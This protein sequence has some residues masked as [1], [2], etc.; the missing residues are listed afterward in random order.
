MKFRHIVAIALGL[1]AVLSLIFYLI[2]EPIQGTSSPLFLWGVVISAAVAFLAGL[3]QIIN[4]VERFGNPRDFDASLKAYLGWV[5][6]EYSRLDLRGVEERQSKAHSLTL[7]DVYV[8]LT[9]AVE[10]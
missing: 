10:R 8:S 4:L 6:N 1:I 2:S 3:D 5:H 7:D 9:V